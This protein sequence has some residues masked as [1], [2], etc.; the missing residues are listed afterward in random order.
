MDGFLVDLHCHTAERSEDADAPAVEILRA[1]V[2]AGLHGVVFTD[3]AR[4]WPADELLAL[5]EEA[6]LPD[7]FLLLAGQEI[8]TVGEDGLRVGDVLVFGPTEDLPEGSAPMRVIEAARAAGGFTI[9]AHLAATHAGMGKRLGDFPIPAAEVWNGRYGP[10]VAQRSEVLAHEFD[11]AM[12]GGSDA[13]RIEQAA[14]GATI[15]PEM[16]RDFAHMAAMI[17]AGACEPWR[18]APRGLLGRLLGR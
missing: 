5:R 2:A 11:V 1:C 17:H 15:F 18:P 14:G 12:T 3:H 13:H 7:R 10:R 6:Q 9:A 8:H 4:T 16:P